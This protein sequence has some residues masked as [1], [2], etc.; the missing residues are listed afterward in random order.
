MAHRRTAALTAL[1]LGAT[2]LTVAGLSPGSAQA[3]ADSTPGYSLRHVTVTV[4]V[5]PDN[6]PCVVDADI[7]KPDKASRTNRKPAILTTNGFGGS[8]DD[9]NESAIGR[10]FVKQ[11]YVVLAYTGLGFP[12][13]GC[14]ITLD[15]PAYDGK[16]GKQMVSVL[17][18]TKAYLDS[19]KQPQR[20]RYVAQESTGRPA[21]RHDRRLLRR[22]GPVRRGDAGQAGRRADPDHHL[23]RPVLLA[24]AQ[25]HEPHPRRHLRHRGRREEAVDRPVLLGRHHRRSAG[26][27]GG[28]V[29]QRPA[30]PQL[31]RRGVPG[32]RQ[33]EHPRLP[34]RRHAPA[35]AARVGLDV[36]QAGHRPH[37]GRAGPEGHAVQ[38][39]GGGGDVPGTARPGHPDPHDLAVVGPLGQQPRRRAS[40]TSTPG[41]CATPTWEGG[42]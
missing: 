23:E 13:S 16:A 31:R 26:R 12:N 18:G 37:A 35:R 20:I 2:G 42:S 32:H 41:R 5:G 27:V 14:K 9:G 39:P 33:A 22:P 8:K 4:K 34:G 36:P 15:D 28:P 24:R 21:G 17:A 10:G 11:G 38:P 29:A 7:Y 30:V 40:S 19:N 1:A 3:A 25:Q 6:H